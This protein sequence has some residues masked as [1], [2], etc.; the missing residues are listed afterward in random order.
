MTQTARGFSSWPTNSARSR[1]PFAP[2]PA[3]AATASVLLSNTTQLWPAR[4]SR[5]TILPP[6]RPRPIIPSCIKTLR[7]FLGAKPP[8]QPSPACGGGSYQASC[9]SSPSPACGGGRA[10][11]RS[12]GRLGADPAGSRQC[13]FEGPA[14]RLQPGIDIGRQVDAQ[15]PPAALRKHVEIA[16]RLRR[17]DHPERVGVA[18]HREILRILA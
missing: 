14:E 8:P 2:S 18:G 12:G 4:I 15:Q 13:L 17:L 5:R 7:R 9:T 11:P 10:P 1:L 3:S 16:A 6:I